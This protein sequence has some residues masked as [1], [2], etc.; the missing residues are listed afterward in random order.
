MAHWTDKTAGRA[1]LAH[2]LVARGWFLFGYS[3]DESDSMTDYYHPADWYG[4]AT[5]AG[6]T[7]VCDIGS[8]S[9]RE[10]VSQGTPV[11]VREDGPC[12]GCKGGGKA[13]HSWPASRVT[14]LLTGALVEDHAAVNVGDPCESCEG[15]GRRVE[16]R[17]HDYPNRWPKFQPN[18]ARCNW[19]VER[20]GKVLASGVGVYACDSRGEGAAKLARLVE[21]IEGAA[22]RGIAA[23]GPSCAPVG[24]VTVT[25][26]K[27]EG[28]SE[29]RFPAPPIAALREELKAAGFRWNRREGCWWGPT[30][31]LP[32]SY[33]GLEAEGG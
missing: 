4:I 33:A 28:Y 13:L 21:R 20:G 22:G 3:K 14:D 15:T 19:H 32:M 26:G 17:R 27:R 24:S 6:T 2:A 31:N 18:P 29:I 16:V 12:S 10:R 1:A 7:V 23:P 11:P 5:K 30:G 8:E 25:P 9:E